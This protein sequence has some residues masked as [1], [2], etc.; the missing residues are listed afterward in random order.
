MKATY[1]VEKETFA[2]RVYYDG[3]DIAGLYQP[4]WPDLT[5][6]SSMEEATEWAKM[7]VESIEEDAAPFP[8]NGPNEE[9]IKKPTLEE[10]EIIKDQTNHF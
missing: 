9:R 7:F 3:S 4:H 1:Q 10:L 6:W 2:I 8:P 5:P